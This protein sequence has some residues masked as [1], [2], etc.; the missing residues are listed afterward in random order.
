VD[1]QN[2]KKE[3][4]N[5]ISEFKQRLPIQITL[6]KVLKISILVVNR[7]LKNKIKYFQNVWDF[8]NPFAVC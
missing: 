1:P 5:K 3:E 4:R 2:K 6:P 7:D 8:S